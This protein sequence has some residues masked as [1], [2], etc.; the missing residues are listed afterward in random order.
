[1]FL[2][3]FYGYIC[4]RT[5]HFKAIVQVTDVGPFIALILQTDR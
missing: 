3:F 1:M 2:N 4:N 5:P